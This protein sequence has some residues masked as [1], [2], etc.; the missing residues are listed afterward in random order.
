MNEGQLSLLKDWFRRA[1]ESQEVHYESEKFFKRIHYALGIP[2]AILSAIVG[3]TIYAVMESEADES[4]K[5]V[6]GCISML[7]A[8]LIALNTFLGCSLKAE[9]HRAAGASYASIR[10]KLERMKTSQE[11]YKDKFDEEMGLVQAEFDSLAS[12]SPVP[13][14]IVSEPT[15]KRLKNTEHNRIFHIPAKEQN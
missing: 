10:R 6:L 13:P 2:A 5:L 9:K 1:R 12:N 4:M 8:A 14:G 11:L 7:S 3:T 15:I